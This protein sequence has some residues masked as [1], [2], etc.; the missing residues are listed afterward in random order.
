MK[1]PTG[2]K[3]TRQARSKAKSNRTSRCQPKV[4][5]TA[6]RAQRLRIAAVLLER[7]SANTMELRTKCNALHPAGR[8]M[9]L[10]EAGWRIDLLWEAANDDQGR[11]HRVGRYVLQ[12]AGGGV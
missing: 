10:R 8:I 3:G 4:T 5:D 11:P 7:G 1:K 9:E 6:R 2:S 12:R